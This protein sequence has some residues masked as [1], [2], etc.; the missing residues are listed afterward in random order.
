MATNEQRIDAIGL[1]LGVAKVDAACGITQD[2]RL[3]AIAFKQDVS[4]GVED[5]RLIKRAVAMGED[6]RGKEPQGDH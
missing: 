6:L 1:L 5:R 3:D 4:F 2:E